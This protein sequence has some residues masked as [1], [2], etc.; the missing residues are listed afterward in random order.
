MRR[1]LVVVAKEPQ[2]GRS[3]TR[4]TPPLTAT[5]ASELYRCLMLDTF[6]LMARLE[7]VQPVVAYTPDEAEEY[8]AGC[9]PAR[10]R[11]TAQQ[12]ADLGDRLDHALREQ[13]SSGCA[14]VVVMNS[15]GPTLPLD[16]LREAFARL[17]R[18]TVDVVLGPSD[19]G[20]YYLVGLKEPCPEIFQVAMSTPTVLEETLALAHSAGL[21]ASLLPTWHD[22][23]TWDDVLRLSDE[24]ASAPSVTATCTRE[25]LAT[26]GL[27]LGIAR[28]RGMTSG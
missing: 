8:F 24:L 17:D 9:A 28:Q 1:A 6:E 12:G 26:L 3:K 14:Q 20:G 11:I 27:L 2:P 22:V 5:E 15:D 23:D 13:L 25:F 19:D 4:L 21:T 10:F 7:A 18:P 16:Y